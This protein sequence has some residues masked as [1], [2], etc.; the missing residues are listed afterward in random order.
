M[1][2]YILITVLASSI[3]LCGATVLSA[4]DPSSNQ[5]T[6]DFADFEKLVW[7]YFG[8]R[9]DFQQTDLIA[10]EDVEPLVKKLAVEG[11]TLKKP[12]D[13]TKRL[14]TKND[15]LYGE[16]YTPAGR[17]MM[18][19]IA[20]YKNGFDRLDRLS[21]LPRGK[22]TVRDLVR[23]PDGQKLIEYM[24]TSAG[25]KNLGKQL[26]QDPNGENFNSPTGR[27]YTVQNLLDY[28][29]KQYDSQ[30]QASK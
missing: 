24:T 21:R 25:G 17:K 28:L 12:D 5:K 13:L 8:A 22:Q 11:L 29:K 19:N 14:L 30:K 4:Q 10:R 1:I 27:I 3:G 2:R 15:F 23:G 7:N 20:T 18:Q 9:K 16:L 26:S 6:K